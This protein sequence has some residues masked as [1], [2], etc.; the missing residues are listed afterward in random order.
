MIFLDDLRKCD[1]D[2]Y[3]C[4]LFVCC[5]AMH[6]AEYDYI[7]NVVKGGDRT[8]AFMRRNGW[9]VDGKTNQEQVYALYGFVPEKAYEE[10]QAK[11]CRVVHIAEFMYQA[12]FYRQLF[13]SA[14]AHVYTDNNEVLCV[15]NGL[16]CVHAKGV[17]VTCVHTRVGGVKVDLGECGTAVIDLM[18]GEKVY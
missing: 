4:V 7:K 14:G 11:S 18:T 6:K 13:A 3:R 1:I 2:N 16:A 10:Y 17:G 15:A 5:E 9:I 8:V 12:E